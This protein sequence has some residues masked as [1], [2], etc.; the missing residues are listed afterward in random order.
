MLAGC[1]LT[2]QR[3][4]GV[5]FKVSQGI[6]GLTWQID[7]QVDMSTAHVGSQKPP[8]SKTAYLPNSLQHQAHVRQRERTTG[9]RHREQRLL[10][11]TGRR[12]DRPAAMFSA[13][14]IHRTALVSWQPLAVA[15]KGQQVNHAKDGNAARFIEL[16]RKRNPSKVSPKVPPSIKRLQLTDSHQVS[17]YPL[18]NFSKAND[19][20][21]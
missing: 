12:G 20:P 18:H 13:S 5:S 19:A 3:P 21:L 4:T 14:A 2:I 9:T 15:T 17:P 8:A 1:V 16:R 7:N 6:A 11:K 10:H